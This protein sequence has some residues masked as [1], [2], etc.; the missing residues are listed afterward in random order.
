MLLCCKCYH[1]YSEARKDF[2]WHCDIKGQRSNCLIHFYF[3]LEQDQ[4]KHQSQPVLLGVQVLLPWGWVDSQ[5]SN[6]G[7]F[8]ILVAST[9][10]CWRWNYW[11]SFVLIKVKRKELSL[12]I[13]SSKILPLEIKV[14]TMEEIQRESELGVVCWQLWAEWSGTGTRCLLGLVSGSV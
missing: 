5:G 2:H 1:C 3:V 4:V 6:K 7:L 8:Q 14:E 10:A 12:Y 11:G 9:T 13:V